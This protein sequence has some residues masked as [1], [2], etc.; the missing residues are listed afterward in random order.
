MEVFLRKLSF[1]SIKY[2][3]KNL[4]FKKSP[5][6]LKFENISIL[7]LSVGVIELSVGCQVFFQFVQ[8]EASKILTLLFQSL[9]NDPVFV[10]DHT[11][12]IIIKPK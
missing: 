5:K 11:R 4:Y 1:S 10:M 6:C 8:L 12:Y 2:R 3:L 9:A 7:S